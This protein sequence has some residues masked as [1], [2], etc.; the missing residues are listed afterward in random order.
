MG[1]FKQL[2]D[3]ATSSIKDAME[4][5]KNEIQE[6]INQRKQELQDNLNQRKQELQE[7][8]GLRKEEA[9]N[10]FSSNR[11]T[12]SSEIKTDYGVIKNGVLEIEEGITELK[13]A[14]LASYKSLKKVVFPSSLT[15][16]ETHV[17]EDNTQLETLDFRKVTK[18]EYIP[19]AF[20]FGDNNIKEFIIP[21]GVKHV[22][23]ASICNIESS[24]P[25]DVYVPATVKEFE[26]FVGYHSVTFHFFT[27]D[28]DIEWLIDDAKQF[29]VLEKDYFKYERQ[30]RQY[31]GDVPL[32][33]MTDRFA[34]IY[35]YLM[36]APE[37]EQEQE[38]E[39]QTK[40]ETTAS[41]NTT[42]EKAQSADEEQIKFSPRIE[43]LIKSAF[44]DGVLTKKEKEIIIK[45]A[46]AEGEDADEFELLLSSRIA[47]D[48]IKEEE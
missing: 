16:L 30:L 43:A 9:R 26:P 39:T 48:G 28:V 14:S 13:D 22:G 1:L 31:G 6:S 47:D 25:L 37:E 29:Y 21:Y 33:H 7:R 34:A 40:A 17:F 18:L 8:M 12:A 19:D 42:T 32:G 41:D 11:P 46:V 36:E 44:R 3:D 23:S 4:Q 2:F 10:S 5:R 15:S 45:R 27:P 24:H 35:Y 20:V 38:E